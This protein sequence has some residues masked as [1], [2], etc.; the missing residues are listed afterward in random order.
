[1]KKFFETLELRI[2]SL[3]SED[4]ITGSGGGPFPGGRDEDDDNGGNGGRPGDF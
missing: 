1:M 2:L 4:I 3:E